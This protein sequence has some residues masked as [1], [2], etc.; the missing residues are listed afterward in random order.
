MALI[1]RDSA[2]ALP[3][4]AAQLI[5]AS[6]NIKLQ[7]NG[8]IENID[9]SND[10][11][12]KQI[13]DFYLDIIVY[14]NQIASAILVSGITAYIVTNYKPDIPA[15]DAVVESNAVIAGINDI[16]NWINTNYPTAGT[17]VWVKH[18]KIDAG[19]VLT[20]HQFTSAAL[21]QVDGFRD[22]LGTLVA[23]FE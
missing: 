7:T 8:L 11:S 12:S 15:Y 22:K 6:S 13:L 4:A 19:N 17:T 18:T 9:A 10:T 3:K 1:T 14:R 21:S 2:S 5:S 16:L 23:L 20:L